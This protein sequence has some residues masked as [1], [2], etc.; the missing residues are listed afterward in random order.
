MRWG[1]GGGDVRCCN[2]RHDPD[3]MP[4]LRSA[5]HLNCTAITKCFC[6]A[7]EGGGGVVWGPGQPQLTLPCPHTHIGKM[8]LC[9]G[10]ITIQEAANWRPIF[11]THTFFCLYAPRVT[12]HRVVAP[13]R[14]PGQSPVLPFAC[15]V[16]SLLS[17]G[18]CGRCSCWCRFRV[19]GA[20]SL[21]CRGCAGCC[22]MCRLRV[23]GAQ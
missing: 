12:V 20:Q 10:N 13:L 5:T 11:G 1:G 19:R 7:R 3:L 14:G 18:R 6:R 9:G 21:V 22:G 4:D 15:C 23:S 17:I 8:F 2:D 16:G